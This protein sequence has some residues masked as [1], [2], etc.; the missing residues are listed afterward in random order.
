MQIM[1]ECPPEQLAARA[2]AKPPPPGSTLSH[3]VKKK[4]KKKDLNGN[5]L[6]RGP[7][8]GDEI[9]L[10]DSDIESNVYEGGF[11]SWEGATDL[12]RLVLER[13]PR[14]D[15]DELARVNSIIEVSALYLF[16]HCNP[17]YSKR[18]SARGFK[19][20]QPEG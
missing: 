11:K 19:R 8:P 14:K 6:P 15:I 10:G 3:E 9:G 18:K 1:A 17:R 13:G 16:C 7:Q 12:A 2:Q 20:L 4:R 5:P